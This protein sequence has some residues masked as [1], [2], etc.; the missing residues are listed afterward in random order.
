MLVIGAG[1]LVL[2]MYDELLE[3]FSS[4][5]RFWVNDLQFAKPAI[6]ATTII[7][8]D[9]DAGDWLTKNPNFI[10][11]VGDCDSRKKLTEKFV[12]LGGI[13][14]KWVSQKSHLST[15][16]SIGI[17]TM[18]LQSTIVEPCV[19]IGKHVLCN[20]RST[21]THEVEIG[22]YTTISPGVILNGACSIGNS[23]FL[24]AGVIV[25]P[26]VKIGNHC[27]IAA[28]AVVTKDIRDNLTVGGVPAKILK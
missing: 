18:I 26:K 14:V 24:G 22:D 19:S 5:I 6:D 15:G 28:G 23:S 7:T 25:L 9:R 16:A 13:P 11:A 21:I 1:G 8:S 2:Q 3:M 27:I 12:A 20:V 4:T 17:G 10:V